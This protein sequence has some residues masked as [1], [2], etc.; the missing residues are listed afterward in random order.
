MAS[1]IDYSQNRKLYVGTTAEV[2]VADG[3]AII[4]GNV[5]IGT[6]SPGEKL[7]VLGKV[8][9][10][11]GS[12]LYID[13]SAT[14]TVFANI[15]NIPMRFQTNSA[16]RFTI[17]GAGAIQFNN[18]D[19]TNNTGTPTYLLGTDSSG[20]IVKTN[21]IPGSAAGPYL[22]LSAG[23]GNGLTGQLWFTG[24]TDANRKIFFTNA[25]AYAKGSMDAAS[26]GFQVSG[27][28]KLTILSTGNVGIGTTSPGYK[29]HVNGG[30]L[31]TTTSTLN[32]IS[33]Y[34]GNGIGAYSST[35]WNIGNY[36]GDLSL[37]NN[38]DDKDIIFKASAG[39]AAPAEIMRIDGSTGKVGIG[40]TSPT[41]LF[42]VVTT[43][44]AS[45]G[46]KKYATYTGQDSGAGT[47]NGFIASLNDEQG[48]TLTANH[49][50]KF[51]ITTT[52]TGTYN[53]SVYIVYRNSANTAWV[54]RAV[55]VGGST[56]NHPLLDISGNNAII[57]DGHSSTYTVRYR[58]ETTNSNQAL[59]SPNIFG[60]D[61]MWQNS[62]GKL[63]Y[64]DGNVGIGTTGPSTK[65]H[66]EGLTRITEGGNTAFYSG[67]YVRLFNSQAYE[68]RNSGGSVIASI[69]LN[70][71]SY[72]NGGKVGIGVT[73]PTN[74]LHV[75][76]DTDNAYAIRIEGS[77]NNG[78]GVW[79]GLGIG[80]ESTNSKSALL[81]EDIGESYARGKL[82]LCVNNE[83]NQNNATPADAKLTIRNDG[84]V[85][86]GTTSPGTKL[87]ITVPG[88]SSQLTLERTGGGAGKVVL[89]GA[90]E[91]L[92]VYDDVYGP[93]MYVG[94]SG[95]YN[96]NVGIGTISPGYK[97]EV[98]G[99]SRFTDTLNVNA[100]ALGAYI[101]SSQN[102]GLIVRGGGNAQDI[103]Q[104]QR[105]GGSTIAVIDSAGDVG[106]GTTSPNQ[107]LHVNGGTQL[108][109]INATVNFGTVALKVVEGTVSTGPTLGSGTVGAQA[110]LYSNG[111]FGMY[112]GVSTNGDT[113][114]Q[115]QRNDT[116]TAA[117]DILLNPLGGN[118]GIGTTS[119]NQKLHIN[120]STAS[121]ASYAKFS[122]AQTGTT[123]AD[124]FD[125]GVNTGAEAIIWQRENANLLFA[126]NNSEKMRITSG[127][128]VGIG[129]TT[130]TTIPL[131]VN[132][133]GSGTIIKA[134]GI[135]AQIEIETSTAGDAHLYMRPNS[136]GNNAAI[137][138]MTAGTNYNWKW[139]DDATTPAV[140][141]KLQQSTGTL[142]V[143]GDVVAYGSPSDRRLKENIKPIESALDKVTKLQGVTFDWKESDSIL[144]IKEDIGFIAQD[145]QKVVPELVR[146]NKDG[147]LSMRHQGIAPILLEAI[148][149]LKA[150]IDLLKS[151]PCNCNKCNCNI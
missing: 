31:Q 12:S 80:G 71:D 5:G 20:N 14:Q 94:T 9:L 8:L 87:H 115:S 145:V 97:L 35:G 93:K 150:E 66:V 68:F 117:Y 131:H 47:G 112:T 56:S 107:K 65:L 109:D 143:S 6:T 63:F 22:P 51:Y 96:G 78:A 1:R 36:V 90:A 105:V 113:W 79:T 58:V 11:N 92:I 146:K 100:S 91:G 135:Q 99:N 50:Y 27:S 104:F 41:D 134:S 141:M 69:N 72:F 21:T 111:E 133:V 37:T 88:G 39:T 59:T 76:T 64:N 29:L 2:T 74:Q 19:S 53:S 46:N 32:R 106:I 148:K 120:N 55:S 129:T 86:I 89:A 103:A 85:G 70:G 16:N 137:F 127:G 60:V 81:F 128:N 30:G 149:E 82:H 123:T 125:V 28:E 140:F 61:S 136:T 73:G 10:N 48:T 44:T 101:Y 43:G 7:H 3:N 121:S 119:P 52:G 57:Y 95:T 13:T 118:V 114:M 142:T 45:F 122:N 144:D 151:K 33:Y 54:E 77:T 18:Y 138:K 26:Y 110:V 126:T 49:Q 24:T 62:A 23:S 132:R 84:N 40:T 17:G 147:M 15:V 108:G 130:N 75:H 98:L 34:D 124:G 139:Q 83:L 38:A 42:T 102:T 25:G 4:D 67:N 116:N